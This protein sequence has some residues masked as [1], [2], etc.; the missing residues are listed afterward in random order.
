MNAAGGEKGGE[1][2]VYELFAV[3]SLEGFNGKVELSLY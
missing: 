3:I 2:I 1:G